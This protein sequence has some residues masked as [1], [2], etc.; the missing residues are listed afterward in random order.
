MHD[1]AEFH[2]RLQG[3]LNDLD[4][5]DREVIALRHFE[6]LTNAEAAQAMGIEVSAASKRYIRPSAV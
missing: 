2:V 5:L 4:P 1:S 3:V 6:E